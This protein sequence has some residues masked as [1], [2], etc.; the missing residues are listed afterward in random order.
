MTQKGIV[1]D[2]GTKVPRLP[3]EEAEAIASGTHGNP[4]SVLG[5]QEFQGGFLAR[6]F[7]PG[8]DDVQALTLDGRPVGRLEPGAVSGLFEGRLAITSRQPLRYAATNSSAAWE[9][10]DPYSYGPVL[11]PMDDYFIAEG[12]H[13]RLFDKMG[14]HPI[15]HE[16]TDG[17]HFAVWAPNARRVSVVGDFNDWDGRR[18][19]MRLRTDVGVWEI[20]A[21]GVRP[22]AAYKYEIIGPNG[23]R[24]PLKADP[25]ARRAELRPAT[26]SIVASSLDHDWGDRAHRAHWSKVDARRQP[27]SIYE[28]HP[29][30][31]RRQPDGSFMSWDQ[32]A[33]EL[34]P[35]C[36]EM[37]FTHIEFL[38]VSEHPYDP[39]WGY[40]TTGLYAPSARFGEPEGFA[41]FVDGAHQVGVGVILDWV[42]AHFPTDEHGLARFDG[43][44]LY[45]HADPRQGFHPDWNTAIY[46]F[47]R[48]EVSS[49]LVNNAL[50]WAETY[51]V[52]G[53]RVDAVASMLYLDYS[54]KE[55]EWIPNKD[56]GRENLDAVEFLKS[57][58]RAVY[59]SHPGI[60]T[61]A[62]E[63]TS[64]PKVSAPV[65]EGGLGFGFK[66]NMGF[67]H[68]TLSYMQRDPIYRKH[69]H[70]DM[71]FGLL[72]AFSENF[73]LP[74]SHDEV[75]HGKGSML[76]KMAGDEWQKFA[77]L[78]A[79]YGFMWGYPGKKLL[80]MGQEFAQ[81][82][83]WSEAR[84]LDWDHLDDP[85]HHGMQDLVRDLNRLYAKT[86]ALHARDCEP[87]GFEWLIADDAANSVFAWV[88]RSPGDKPVVI[89]SNFTPNVLTGYQ[90]PMPH[91]GVWLEI[92]NSDSTV[93]G[94]SGKGNLGEVMTRM[95]GDR[96]I[97]EL[98]LPPLATM[99]FTPA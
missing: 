61:I 77:S 54:R 13:L 43:T 51:H 95:E 37:G 44:A 82:G 90:V 23:E 40:Q 55:G 3:A 52:D 93:Y 78:R 36:V 8:A 71:T 28:V 92:F 70:A 68:D 87:E 73:V 12:S 91:D 9:A 21:P 7:V 47:G 67:M 99:M 80:F 58:N 22:G 76:N 19:V 66:W 79:Y 35:Y 59:G 29:G 24:L 20:F 30:S 53:L 84:S 50:F 15:R 6:A 5:L 41:R 56:G 74:I 45:E 69:H 62:E 63:S 14:A 72:Y 16:G 1:P 57:M 83:E 32:M 75:V 27:M 64:W 46:N 33:D 39:S 65:H 42:P 81:R 17:V 60:V 31:W 10:E 89:V 4:F 34:I 48:R 38:P 97:A 18:H 49:F 11:G 96:I 86:P 98:T 88:R 26:A 25:Y 94:G 2:A 85:R